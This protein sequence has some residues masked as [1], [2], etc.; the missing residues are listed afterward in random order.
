MRC[1]NGKIKHQANRIVFNKQ[2]PCN[3]KQGSDEEI[4]SHPDT[5]VLAMGVNF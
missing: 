3:G 2:S 1:P 5:E 4:N